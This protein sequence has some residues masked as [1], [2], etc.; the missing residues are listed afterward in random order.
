MEEATFGQWIR[1]WRRTLRLTQTELGDLVGLSGAMIRKI[2]AGERRPAPDVAARFAQALGLPADLHTAFLDVARQRLPVAY[3]PEPDSTLRS[4]DR[5]VQALTA[6]SAVD[7]STRAATSPEKREIG[8]PY[9]GLRAFTEADAAVFFGR[10]GLTR[11]LVERLNQ[12][13][14]L[15][16]FLLVVGPSGSGKSS[17]VR[18]GLIP[19]LRAGALPGSERWP[20]ALCTPG[21]DP[22]AA[23]HAAVF[24]VTPASQ[25]T[26]TDLLLPSSCTQAQPSAE[27]LGAPATGA[28]VLVIDQFEELWTLCADEQVRQQMLAGIAAAVQQEHGGVRVIATL[29]AD[30][31][32]RPLVPG[33]SDLVRE[34]TEVVVPLAFAELESAIVEPAAVAG[35]TFEPG[36]VATIMQDV[37]DQPGTLPLLQFLLTEL[38]E[39]REAGMM[40]RS[41]Y[42]R[43]GGLHGA[44]VQ[45]A[46]NV[47]DG[48][49][50]NEQAAARQVLQRLVAVGEGTDDTRR[51]VSR[52]ELIDVLGDEAVCD[53][54]THRFI[55]HRLLTAD[56]DRLKAA[57]TLEIAHE[58]LIQRWGRVRT[59]LDAA[60]DDLIVH[61]QLVAAVAD[62]EAAEMDDSFLATGI[63]YARF[64][65]L[66]ETDLRLTVME[67][68]YL[69]ASN[70]A[71]L[72]WQHAE[73]AARQR[74]LEQTR[75]LAAEQHRRLAIE[76]QRADDQTRVSRRLRLG[77]A[78]LAIVSLIALGAAWYGHDQARR[79]VHQHRLARA[80][81]R[82]AQ[83][84]SVHTSNP[85][86]SLLLAAEAI[87]TTRR[88]DGF[89]I[90]AAEDA[91]RQALVDVSG[92]GLAG[93][94]GGITAVRISDNSRWLVTASADATARV[95]DLTA[96]DPA[97]SVQVLIGHT[98]N[99][100]AIALSADS[101]WVITGSND[102]TAR[103]WDLQAADPVQTVREL[104]GHQG[105]VVSVAI[106]QD[107]RWVVTGSTDGT[108]RVWDLAA[109]DPA[110]SVHALVGHSN[111]IMSVAIS[112]DARWVVTGSADQSV[113]IWS[114]DTPEPSVQPVVL[115]GHTDIV[116]TVAL[117]SDRRWIVSHSFDGTARVWDLTSENPSHTAHTLSGQS[118]PITSVALSADNRWIVAGSSD[119]TASVW[120]LSEQHFSSPAHVLSGHDAPIRSVAI[121]ADSRWV[122]TNALNYNVRV[123]DLTA[124]DP[125]ASSRVLH[126]H[127]DFVNAIAVSADG[128]WVASGSS[129]FTARVWDLQAAYPSDAI[130]A[131]P[132]TRAQLSSLALSSDGRWLAT[133]STDG[134]ASVWD[135]NTTD[136]LAAPVRSLTHGD[137][138]LAVAI[139]A[140]GHR[141]VTAGVD[142]MARVWDLTASDPAAEPLVLRGHTDAVESVAISADARWVITGSLDDTARVWDLAARNPSAAVTVLR[143]HAADIRGVAIS[144][145]NRW[146]ATGSDDYTARVWDLSVPDPATTFRELRGHED[147]V[148]AVAI[149]TDGRQVI[150]GSHDFTARVWNVQASTQPPP[151]RVLRGH[152]MNVL[153]V[154]VSG[155][156]RWVV[157]G[158]ADGSARIWDVALADP[159][160]S[161][162]T[163]R[164][165][166]GGAFIGS[167]GTSALGDRIVTGDL[168]TGLTMVWE[169][170]LDRLVV[171]LLHAPPPCRRFTPLPPSFRSSC[172]LRSAQRNTV[173]S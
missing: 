21:E 138:V 121:S 1:R 126:G 111:T 152:V 99:V 132:A 108:A 102:S 165:R 92:R 30:F 5:F 86:Q 170:R 65:S 13:H 42:T 98:D 35:V 97:A 91:L 63:R 112:D 66:R 162:R 169:T 139:S 50:A 31:Y 2:E 49:T 106:S 47:Y 81:Q 40:N 153:A 103:V 46:E 20:I 89:V 17:L 95:W 77:F 39:R 122:I 32:D 73:D 109:N 105:W 148:E 90:P 134:T 156:D 79:A 154:A 145:D 140:D 61:R 171:P 26:P 37:D 36:L 29:R 10:D 120:N 34:R 4:P 150:T 94:D 75:A 38:Y 16:R 167:V 149:S 83:S 3:L 27:I 67:R 147:A 135:L 23:L 55:R 43:I 64:E 12:T 62:W 113:R 7:G 129:D 33:F 144:A 142:H 69:D 115:R 24:R 60:R 155:D 71:N 131:I 58:A 125:S 18:A 74:E 127:E 25:G 161:S 70:A 100:E 168:T 11:R 141:A 52:R 136:L 85:Q 133:G 116:D 59:W 130:R 51:R 119:F 93:H 9:R 54:V 137:N 72:A 101:R 166:N 57:P 87:S 19:A 124:P 151:Y 44:L 143:G 28:Y 107:A 123:Y 78:V 114:L 128:R 8:N 53:R 164:H 80:G 56:F 96:A 84:Q 118:G 160:S 163:L 157:T 76:Q 173:E 48:L 41:T 110:S 158:S 88:Y 117:S 15:H 6:Q 82:A 159:S 172:R 22:I 68:A 146:A 45:R 14:P 104:R